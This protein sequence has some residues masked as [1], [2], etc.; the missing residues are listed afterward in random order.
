MFAAHLILLIVAYG[1]V[2]LAAPGPEPAPAAFGDQMVQVVTLSHAPAGQV[3]IA[4]RE[5]EFPVASTTAGENRVILRGSAKDVELVL[6][7]VVSKLDVP[8]VSAGGGSTI[9]YIP[10]SQQPSGAFLSLLEA[11]APRNFATHY[12]VD[13]AGRLIAVN[14]P[15]EQ[16][17][18]IRKLVE[19]TDRPAESFLIHFYFLR[20]K[21]AGSTPNA[22][23]EALPKDLVPVAAGLQA[24]GFA[25]LELIGPLIIQAIDERSFKSSAVQV[26]SGE[27]EREGYDLHVNGK[28]FADTAN[29]IVQLELRVEVMSRSAQKKDPGSAGSIPTVLSAESTIA[30]KLDTCVVLAAAPSPTSGGDAFAVAVKVTRSTPTK[31]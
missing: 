2:V 1:G 4:I 3:V 10:L 17:A 25:N 30:A 19:A 21:V 5:L 13:P 24:A 27:D 28:P 7:Q 16:V 23:R 29:G 14:A 22:T 12:A 20:A 15:K 9:D 26:R 18:A 8:G 6:Q 31:P 11:V